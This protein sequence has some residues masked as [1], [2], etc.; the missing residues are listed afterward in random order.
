MVVYIKISNINHMNIHKLYELIIN[1][2]RLINCLKLGKL[3]I[4][5]KLLMAE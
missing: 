2:K 5:I 3:E 1:K 4:V